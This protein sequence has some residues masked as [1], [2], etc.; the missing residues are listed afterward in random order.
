L[1]YSQVAF[2]AVRENFQV[3]LKKRLL[4]MNQLYFAFTLLLVLTACSNGNYGR[5]ED[6]RLGHNIFEITFK[7]SP[8]F[9][10]EEA[11]D[12]CL[13]R[14]AEV[15]INRGYKYF[16][17][18]NKDSGLYAYFHPTIGGEWK[19]SAINTVAQNILVC[20]NELPKGKEHLFL[21]AEKIRY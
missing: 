7:G 10:N 12:I 21:N 2:D 14:C 3:I 9:S 16:T 20:T 1:H 15:T 8:S 17:V 4:K 19:I 18:P 5:F 13:R 11:R 6:R